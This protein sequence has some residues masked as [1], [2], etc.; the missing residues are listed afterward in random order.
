MKK[1][2]KSTLAVAILAV[3]ATMGYVSYNQYQN[4]QLA[5]ANPLMEENIEALAD[6]G[7]FGK[8]QRV[9][10][11]SSQLVVT[12]ITGSINAGVNVTLNAVVDGELGARLQAE[13]KIKCER[14]NCYSIDCYSN[15]K[16]NTWCKTMGWT[17]S[18]GNNPKSGC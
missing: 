11:E 18:S 8:L 7:S 10:M 15:D 12:S 2:F 6:N 17:V 5:F 9:V 3:S 16:C 1:I 4:Q 13:G 14:K